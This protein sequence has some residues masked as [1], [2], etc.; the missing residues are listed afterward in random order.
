M[1]YC[2]GTMCEVILVN[3]YRMSMECFVGSYCFGTMWEVILEQCGN[4]CGML[5]VLL[6]TYYCLLLSILLNLKLPCDVWNATIICIACI[7]VKCY[8]MLCDLSCL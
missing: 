3:W 4:V 2:F 1:Y 8:G 7:I 5:C 6:L